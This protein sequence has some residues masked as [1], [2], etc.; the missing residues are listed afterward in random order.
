MKRFLVLLLV[1]FVVLFFACD[2]AADTTKD[3]AKSEVDEILEDPDADHGEPGTYTDDGGPTAEN[4][5]IEYTQSGTGSTFYISSRYFGKVSGNTGDGTW[6][7]VTDDNSSVNSGT[8]PTDENGEYGLTIPVFCGGQTIK[9]VWENDSGKLTIVLHYTV[10]ACTKKDIRLT[11]S[12][13]ENVYDLEL[14]LIREGGKLNNTDGGNYDCTWT[15]MNPDWGTPGDD[16]D[17]PEKD[18]D[19]T[20]INGVENIMLSNPENVKYTV[21]VEYWASGDPA[22]AVLVMNVNG[23]Q[24]AKTLKNFNPNEVWKAAE[25]DWASNTVTMFDEI[26][27]CTSDWSSGCQKSLP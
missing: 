21:M 5:T 13:G 1:P 18:I 10:T 22:E 26:I 12:W 23:K 6:Y 15:N 7:I 19:E 24:Y 4:K 11:L 2:E 3:A 17:D 20:G 8:I 9:L 16:S 14:H 27:D 25:I